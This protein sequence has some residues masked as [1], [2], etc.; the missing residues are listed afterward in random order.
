MANF[1][2]KQIQEVWDKA[3]VIEGYDPQKFRK[4]AANAWISFSDYGKTTQFGWTIDHVIPQSMFAEGT[5][6]AKINKEVNLR[7]MHWRNNQSKKDSFPE[8]DVAVTS[9][10]NQNIETKEKKIV[11]QQLFKQLR[12]EYNLELVIKSNPDVYKEYYNC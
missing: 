11:N 9:Y 6:P 12:Q 1:T 3:I 2:T 7:A 4:D 8:Y 10:G 5:P